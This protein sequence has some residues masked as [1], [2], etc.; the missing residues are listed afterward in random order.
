MSTSASNASNIDS[1]PVSTGVHL[2]DQFLG[3][4]VCHPSCDD[5]DV[6]TG[7]EQGSEFFSRRQG[8][9]SSAAAERI[10]PHEHRDRLTVPSDCHLLAGGDAVE[11]CWQGCPCFAG[12][13]RCHQS[14][15]QRRTITYNGQP[16]TEGAE[17]SE[18]GSCRG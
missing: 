5:R 7:G 16:T 10:G 3:A 12:C 6:A 11:Q 13:H 2:S 8:G 18:V 4:G 9:V 1:M 15:V 17:V 14:T